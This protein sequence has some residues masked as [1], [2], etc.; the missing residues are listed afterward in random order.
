MRRFITG[1]VSL[2]LASSL[3]LAVGCGKGGGTANCEGVAKH[4]LGLMK[5][6]PMMKGFLEKAPADKFGEMEKEFA[7]K[8]KEERLPADGLACLMAAKE[9]KDLQGCEEKF[10]KKNAEDKA[11]EAPT[12]PP[13]PTPEPTAAPTPA[14]AG[15]TAAPTPAPAPA[16]E[17]K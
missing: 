17:V 2:C 11:P 16:P 1:I 5:N 4:V 6:D 14:P 7:S 9:M 10:G 15:D 8:C 13:T 3:V 12:P